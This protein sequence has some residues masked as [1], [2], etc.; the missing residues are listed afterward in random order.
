MKP[1][2]R[3]V[4]HAF[5]MDDWQAD[6]TENVD[7]SMAYLWI[8]PA[9]VGGTWRWNAEGSGGRDVQLTLKQQYQQLEGS[10]RLGDKTG[11]LRD[12]KLEGDQI[13]FSV[14]ESASVHRDYAGRVNGDSIQGT[15]KSSG[16]EAKWSAKRTSTP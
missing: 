5:T 14:Y 8:V 7:G 16:G 4:S 11:Q 12:L 10:A 15:V 9:R 1:G 6:Q 13:T 2:T 3:V